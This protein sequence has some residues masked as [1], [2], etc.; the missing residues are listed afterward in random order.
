MHKSLCV[1]QDKKKHNMGNL[2]ECWLRLLHT[3]VRC[4]VDVKP[5]DKKYSKEWWLYT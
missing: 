4:H 3:Q 5:F 1:N 2:S